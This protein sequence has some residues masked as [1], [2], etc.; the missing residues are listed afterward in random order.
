MYIFYTSVFRLSAV[1][2]E[3]QLRLSSAE[4]LRSDSRIEA[5]L[6]CWLQVLNMCKFTN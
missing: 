2:K 6:K 5:T 1:A 3:I 4:Y